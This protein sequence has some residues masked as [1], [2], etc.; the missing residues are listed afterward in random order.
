MRVNRNYVLTEY[1]LNENDCMCVC[2]CACV[3]RIDLDR[4]IPFL[5]WSSLWSAQRSFNNFAKALDNKLMT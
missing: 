1:I 3:Y 2:V 4:T 5:D